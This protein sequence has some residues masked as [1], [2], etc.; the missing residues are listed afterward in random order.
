MQIRVVTL[1]PEQVDALLGFGV[2]ARAVDAGI[3]SVETVDPRSFT[4]DA[5]RTVDDRPYGGGPG[6][7][8]MARPITAAVSAARDAMP[9]GSRVV[10][11]GPQGRVF[12]QQLACEFAE[13]PG[14]VLV[15]GRYE[16]FDERL[17]ESC[18]DDEVSIGD[19]VLTGGE[20]AAAAV[21]D[22]VLRLLP[23]TLGDAA[24]AAQDSF[25]DGLLDCPH[26]TR[27]EVVAGKAVPDVLLGGNHQEIRRWRL[28]QALGRTCSRRP[29]LLA[30][31][32]LSAEERELL[33]EYLRECG[34]D[35][36]TN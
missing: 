31:R 17:V 36:G 27:P 29:D 32:V 23:G 21:V 5:H 19:Y 25:M 6:M 10:F 33:D 34:P 30:N 18:A 13:L 11:L 24:S 14:L 35:Q 4:D 26:Y 15:S 3:A 12:N 1:F 20:I 28:K 7:V 8:L 9:E 2:G 16:G 22:S